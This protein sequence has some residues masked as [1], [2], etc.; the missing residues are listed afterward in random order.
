MMILLLLLLVVNE[1]VPDGFCMK[2][3]LMVLHPNSGI[4]P[5]RLASVSVLFPE[6]Y[7]RR[8]NAEIP[9]PNCISPS[10]FKIPL[11]NEDPPDLTLNTG[12]LASVLLK[13]NGSDKIVDGITALVKFLPLKSIEVPVGLRVRL[14]VGVLIVPVITV[15]MVYDDI[16]VNSGPRQITRGTPNETT[17]H[18]LRVNRQCTIN[19]TK[20]DFRCRNV[21]NK[22]GL[23]FIVG[24]NI[25]QVFLYL[26]PSYMFTAQPKFDVCNLRNYSSAL[27][28]AS[29]YSQM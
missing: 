1:S 7:S 14:P 22:Q 13:S 20:S 21:Q 9:L 2:L 3:V 15:S 18:S 25:S 8:S 29:I 26:A 17:K 11:K 4:C 10:A 16:N 23:K 6:R 19:R 27:P 24:V 28:E 12:S 5:V